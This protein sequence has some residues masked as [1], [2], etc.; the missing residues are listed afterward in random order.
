MSLVVDNRQNTIIDES[1]IILIEK[2]VEE[3][4]KYEGWDSS[5]EVSLSLVD[6]EEIQE[7]NK[8]YRGKDYS[9]DVLSFP[10]VEDEYM[11]DTEEKL[12]G[13]IVLSVEKALEQADEYGHS[14]NREV[15]FL[16]V[17]SMLHLM[18]YDHEIDSEKEIMRK[19]EEAILS[20][21][22]QVRQ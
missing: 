19:K 4:L 16:V 13:D 2:A 15:C 21:L 3:S 18:G 12:L 8:T 14:F 6:N 7:L 1:L 20:L 5:Y 22:G 10:M 11:V 9:T 17:H